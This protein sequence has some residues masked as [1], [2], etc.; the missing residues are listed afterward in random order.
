MKESGQPFILS[1]FDGRDMIG[2]ASIISVTESVGLNVAT[3]LKPY[4]VMMSCR[5]NC[6]L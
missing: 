2:R 1:A 6:S 4:H 3:H 5:K